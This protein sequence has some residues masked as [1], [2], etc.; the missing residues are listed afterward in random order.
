MEKKKTRVVYILAAI[1]AVCTLA[2]FIVS[3]VFSIGTASFVS[4]L[5]TMLLFLVIIGVGIY[6]SIISVINEQH[7]ATKACTIFLVAAILLTSLGSLNTSEIFNL[8]GR[9]IPDFVN[10]SVSEVIEWGDKNNVPITQTTEYSDSIEKYNIV[11]QSANPETKVSEIEE[12]KISVSN[13]PDTNLEVITPDF[14]GMKVDDVV[15]KIKE[16]KLSNVLIEYKFSDAE[17]D[18]LLTQSFKGKMKRNK[19]LVLTFSLGKEA[20]LKPVK[21]I[22][23]TNKTDFDAMLWLKRNGIK[24]TTK[25]EFSDTIKKFNII[26]TDPIKDTMIDQKKVNLSLYISKGKEIV[27]PDVSKMSVSELTNWAITNHLDLN[28]ENEYH[29]SIELGKVI[30]TN[31]KKDQKIS[32][33]FDLLIVASKG[34]LKMIDATEPSKISAWAAENNIPIK[35]SEEFSDKIEKGKI[36]SCSVKAGDVIKSGS[37]IELVISLGKPVEVPDVVGLS[38]NKASTII[39]AAKLDCN[40]IYSYSSSVAKGNVISQSLGV[41]S[42]VAEGTTMTINVSSGEYTPPN[43][44]GGSTAPA[45]TPD[46]VPVGCVGSQTFTLYIQPSL[47]GTTANETI[48]SLRSAWASDYPK[49][50]FNFVVSASNEGGPGQVHIDTVNALN[51]KTIKQC[52]TYTIKIVQ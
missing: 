49:V 48:A 7:K 47:Y 31:V 52:E 18:M 51:G 20:D 27:V 32:E 39:S 22:D 11:Y 45:P 30:R 26:K 41:G 50:K 8:N 6:V 10:A 17:R 24:F 21:M 46:P 23:L 43:N 37:G 5:I 29:E 3:I 13:G 15:A 40:I 16:L 25:R 36:I 14:T 1:A 2:S 9:R 12:L 34:Q 28:I 35:L 4:S 44:G 33:G 42:K 38:S 19:E